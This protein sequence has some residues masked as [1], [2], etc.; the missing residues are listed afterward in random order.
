MS[1]KEMKS[2]KEK[3]NN[4]PQA[5]SQD[6]RSN[7]N[8]AVESLKASDTQSEFNVNERRQESNKEQ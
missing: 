2:S 4:A 7:K 1:N 5:A 8:D 3:T 6:K